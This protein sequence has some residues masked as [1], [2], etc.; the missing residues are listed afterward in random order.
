MFASGWHGPRDMCWRKS[1]YS[2]NGGACV[3]AAG[4]GARVAVRDSKSP[5]RGAL[6]FR[7]AAWRAFVT[8]AKRGGFDRSDRLGTHS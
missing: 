6:W 3:E 2:G 8:V 7:H 5:A 1:S 4:F